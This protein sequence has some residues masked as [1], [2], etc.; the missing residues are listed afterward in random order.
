M[1]RPRLLLVPQLT[2]LEWRIKPL[3]QEW[4]EVATYDAPGVGDEPP[5]DDL[6]PAAIAE[7][8]LREVDERGWNE[9][10]VVADE[11]G[12]MAAT[13]LACA[14]PQAVQGLAIGHACLENTAE[15]ERPTVNPDVQAA[16]AQIMVADYRTFALAM[17]QL[18]QGS[19]D[20]ELA[21]QY[22]ERVPQQLAT[23]F[24]AA[25]GRLPSE[26]LEERLRS[27]D[28]PLLF[29]EHKDCV[30]HTREGFQDAVAAFPEAEKVR[31]PDKPSTCPEFAA[32]LREFCERVGS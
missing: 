28:C 32:R 29:A 1:G 6:T 16:F 13:R 30:F 17:T 27:L 2:E 23:L 24:L 7:R 18:T 3:L 31:V 4:A 14:R 21:D 22:M 25:K 19:Y 8:G 10:V 11:L 26:P 12:A 20:E 9:Y 5:V 15:G